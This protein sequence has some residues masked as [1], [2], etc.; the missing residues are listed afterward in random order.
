M[1][2]KMQEILPFYGILFNY[3]GEFNDDAA[4]IQRYVQ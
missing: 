3:R 2:C 1:L 4:P